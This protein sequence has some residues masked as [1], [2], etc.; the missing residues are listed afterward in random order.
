MYVSRR[1]GSVTSAP[2]QAAAGKGGQVA[3][4]SISGAVQ[5]IGINSSK[6]VTAQTPGLLRAVHQ[7][8]RA[9][10]AVA[11]SVPVQPAGDA[12]QHTLSGVATTAVPGP[13]LRHA[14]SVAYAESGG[15]SSRDVRPGDDS[16]QGLMDAIRKK[17]EGFNAQHEAH[18]ELIRITR[19][20]GGQ[21]AGKLGLY[22]FILTGMAFIP[23]RMAFEMR[24]GGPEP[25]HKCEFKAYV[26]AFV[27][28]KHLH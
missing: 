2:Q 12:R 9:Q 8:P 7:Q 11:Y 6:S 15:A 3:A 18:I 10:Q 27:T 14:A 17:W 24:H 21:Q 4:R 19:R 20:G 25:R 5:R 26:V 28:Y 22:A 1:H 16:W 23:T 13:P